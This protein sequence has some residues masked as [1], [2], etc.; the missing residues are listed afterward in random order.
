MSENV[1]QGS[2]QAAPV[3]VGMVERGLAIFSGV[4]LLVIGARMGGI[5]GLIVILCGADMIFRGITGHS[6][7]YRLFGVNTAAINPAREAAVPHQQG[8]RIEE[9]IVINRPVDVVYDYWRNFE[10]LP[11]FMRNLKDVDVIDDDRSRWTASG[12]AGITLTWEA[13]IINEKVDEMIAWRTTN[14]ASVPHAGTVTMK[15]T[16]D[17]RAAELTLK[18]EYMPPGGALG[19]MFAT[20]LGQNPQ[21]QTRDD[22]QRLKDILEAETSEPH[23]IDHSYGDTVYGLPDEE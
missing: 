12:P 9:C 1:Q 22:L 19:Q 20:V 18:M 16:P 7:L 13:E 15:A 6:W 2:A 8:M 3:D 17:G 21:K 10:N 23:A 4:G 5:K 14:G 11:T